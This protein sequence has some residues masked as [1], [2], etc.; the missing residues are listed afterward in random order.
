MHIGEIF[1]DL[2]KA[3]HCVNHKI[4]LTK[5]HFYGVRGLSENWI[6]SYLTN[7]RQ[8]VAVRSLNTAQFFF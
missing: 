8:K 7:K 2:A 3:F 6:R 4:L 5:L 1:W